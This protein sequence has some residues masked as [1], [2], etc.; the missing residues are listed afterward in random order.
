MKRHYLTAIVL[1]VTLAGLALWLLPKAWRTGESP[2]ESGRV[3]KLGAFRPISGTF[4]LD[5]ESR[6]EVPGGMRGVLI[7]RG[8][9]EIRHY[10][11]SRSGLSITRCDH[12][13][14]RVLEQNVMTTDDCEREVAG[15][16]V[17]VEV[18]THQRLVAVRTAPR[19]TERAQQLLRGLAQELAFEQRPSATWSTSEPTPRGR[20]A[21]RYERKAETIERRRL[22]YLD[23]TVGKLLEGV[24]TVGFDDG[25]LAELR[26]SERFPTATVR[27]ELTRMGDAIAAGPPAT[28]GWTRHGFD[29]PAATTSE[30]HLRQRI[31]GMTRAEFLS[32]LDQFADGGH[33]PD[34]ERFIWRA[35][36]LLRLEPALT[37]ELERRFTDKTATHRR[38]ALLLDLLASVSTREAQVSM[39]RMLDTQAAVERSD[40]FAHY[41]QRLSIVAKPDRDTLDWIEAR[42]RAATDDNERIACAYTLGSVSRQHAGETGVV[43][44]REAIARELER[45]VDLAR[46]ELERAHLLRA[47]G[48]TA[49]PSA[50]RALREGLASDSASM[51]LAAIGGLA[52][53]GIED[54]I[55]D[56]IADTNADVQAA[57]LR[58]LGFSSEDADALIPVIASQGLPA[59]SA[60]SLIRSLARSAEQRPEATRRIAQALIRAGYA[61]GPEAMTL[62]TLSGA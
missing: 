13:E 38:R 57:A 45:D 24:T 44:R 25:E 42:Y 33:F 7:L 32:A 11:G 22:R 37:R 51:R 21:V 36:G 14:W 47:L 30:E 23:G 19:L 39:R 1:G 20:A 5:Y 40:R 34:H 41:V 3:H 28:K 49:S 10:S 16:E 54:A 6:Q 61:S 60:R 58:H 17:L 46:S 59:S 18:G 62:H 15:Q 2:A 56:A 26:L 4:T 31:A 9:L 27:L 52:R 48:A 8:A 12:I 53:L 35:T 29:Q 55:R 43:S 50:E